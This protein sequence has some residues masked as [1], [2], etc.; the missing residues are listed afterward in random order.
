MIIC[1]V[2][3]L[4]RLGQTHAAHLAR[5]S[6]MF[7][8]DVKRIVL[9]ML[10]FKNFRCARAIIAGIETMHFIKKNQLDGLKDRAPSAAQQFYSL[11]F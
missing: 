6:T 4:S 11:A 7:A 2:D 3:L 1:K 5:A 9:P 8:P 10:G